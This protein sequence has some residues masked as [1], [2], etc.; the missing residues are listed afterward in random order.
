MSNENQTSNKIVI[1]DIY[2]DKVLAKAEEIFNS[3]VFSF[4]DLL[5]KPNKSILMDFELL[6][7]DTIKQLDDLFINVIK[8]YHKNGT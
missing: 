2:N 7:S 4:N 8:K 5:K 3:F 6:Y 1:D